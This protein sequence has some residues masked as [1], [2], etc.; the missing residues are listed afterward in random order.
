MT[1]EL[2]R[3]WL[4]LGAIFTSKDKIGLDIASMSFTL[5]IL[6][7]VGG[8]LGHSVAAGHMTIFS[9]PYLSQV[10]S[11]MNFFFLLWLSW[12]CDHWGELGPLQ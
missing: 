1:V 6:F 9:R 10:A 4:L 11:E 7:T 5:C 8:Y 3:G 12:L 2:F